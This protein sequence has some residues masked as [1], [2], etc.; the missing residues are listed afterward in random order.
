MR[1]L[2]RIYAE[3]G[4]VYAAKQYTFA[5]ASI[6]L[7]SEQP[8]VKP[9]TAH[10]LLEAADLSYVAGNWLDAAA[11][12]HIAVIARTQLLHDPFD[13]ETYPDLQRLDMAVLTPLLAA[14]TFWPHIESGLSASLDEAAPLFQETASEVAAGIEWSEEQFQQSVSDQLRG[15]AFADTGSTRTIQFALLGTAWAITCC[16]DRTSVLAAERLTAALQIL[17]PELVGEPTALLAQS[18]EIEVSVETPSDENDRVRLQPSNDALL[19]SVC[20]TDGNDIADPGELELELTSIATQ[21]LHLI[22]VRPFGELHPTIEK[23]FRRGLM[24]KLHVA[25]PYDDLVGILEGE[26]Y[27]RAAALTRPPTSFEPTEHPAL[28]AETSPGPGYDHSQSLEAIRQRYAQAHRLL[29]K[30]LPQLLSHPGV[31]QMVTGLRQQGWLDWQILSTLINV[32]GNIRM[33][34]AGHLLGPGTTPD[35]AQKFFLTPERADDEP[36]SPEA[37]L[38][39]P[40]DFH[41]NTMVCA[42]AN[43]WGLET[44]IETP[45]VNA[46]R[47]LLTRRYGFGVDVEHLDPLDS[48]RED[49]SLQPFLV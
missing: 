34:N 33:T 22:N 43:G 47:E 36:I 39:E 26:H 28:A 23:I 46:L 27:T 24:H 10:A 7:R 32:T 15:P 31:R 8:E 35:V 19:C 5:A 41:L 38:A 4:L 17:L 6:A 16:N 44:H 25:R 29:P 1:F 18:V 37:I 12:A 49:G 40:I 42:V 13:Y 3:L 14:R 20:L 2:S 30:T 21:L 48:V 45:N 9:V 11:T